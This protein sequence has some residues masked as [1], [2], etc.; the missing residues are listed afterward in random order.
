MANPEHLAILKRGVEEWNAWRKEHEEVRP[1]LRRA[2]LLGADLRAA[3]LGKATLRKATL[4]EADLSLADLSEALLTGAILY[5]ANLSGADLRGAILLT[6]EQLSEAKTLF[7][8]KLDSTLMKQ[9]RQDY[10]Y[11]LEKPNGEK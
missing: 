6:A 4:S 7:E 8:A 2:N 5:E 10:Q 11:L 3:L 9:I 1:D